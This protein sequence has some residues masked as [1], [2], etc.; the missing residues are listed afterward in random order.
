M[1]ITYQHVLLYG[2]HFRF[3]LTYYMNVFLMISLTVVVKINFFHCQCQC[4]V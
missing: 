4:D 1:V 3:E 2:L